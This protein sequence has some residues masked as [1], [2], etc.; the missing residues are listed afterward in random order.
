MFAARCA[1]IVQ[2]FNA[3]WL[4]QGW[5]FH[6][7][8]NASLHN[9]MMRSHAQV[10]ADHLSIHGNSSAHHDPGMAMTQAKTLKDRQSFH[11]DSTGRLHHSMP[12]THKQSVSDHRSFHNHSKNRIHSDMGQHTKIA[13]DEVSQLD[14][15]DPNAG[16]VC[17]RGCEGHG[18]PARGPC[19]G[20]KRC[21]DQRRCEDYVACPG[22]TV[23]QT[24]Q[25]GHCRNTCRYNRVCKRSCEGHGCPNSGPCVGEKSCSNTNTLSNYIQCPPGMEAFTQQVGH[26]RVN[27]RR[28]RCTSP[29]VQRGRCA[30]G[31][32]I[33]QDGE[34]TAK[35]D[36]GYAPSVAKLKCDN[37][38]LSPARFTC[39]PTRC[40]LPSVKHGRCA[41][42]HVLHGSRCTAKCDPG[43]TVSVA[44]L[45][46]QAQKFSP[47]SFTCKPN[48]CTAPTIENQ[49]E[50]GS[51]ANGSNITHGDLCIAQCKSGYDAS[52]NLSCHLGNLTPQSFNCTKKSCSVAARPFFIVATLFTLLCIEIQ[53]S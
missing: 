13:V 20:E 46:C 39:N 22:G 10:R 15:S 38:R 47:A 9:A 2:V 7:Q 31:T 52:E 11:L 25:V 35:C 43:Y 29:T 37:Q 3:C 5:Q 4:S 40:K 36:A 34:C 27:C 16:R 49:N 53:K 21:S 17:H 30:E 33:N 12:M 26:C 8:K 24:Q 44:K 45:L 1:C 41:E 42:D 19:G 50:Q 14:S 6:D 51:C 32:H 18:C 23:C 28:P 48:N